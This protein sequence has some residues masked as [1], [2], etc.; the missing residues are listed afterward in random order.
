MNPTSWTLSESYS[1]F[2]SVVFIGLVCV[3]TPK[4]HPRAEGYTKKSIVAQ[5]DYVGGIM[6]IAGITLV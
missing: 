5:L 4:A 6:S 1:A 3:Y 2:G